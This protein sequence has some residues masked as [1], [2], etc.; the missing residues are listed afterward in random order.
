M[1]GETSYFEVIDLFNKMKDRRG[2]G[3]GKRIIS[4]TRKIRSGKKRES[5][6]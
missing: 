2:S 1:C 3:E 6:R 4:K 5:R